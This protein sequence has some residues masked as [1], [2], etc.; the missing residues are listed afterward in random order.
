M[1]AASARPR[2]HF[3]ALAAV[4]TALGFSLPG[5]ALTI[6]YAVDIPS[7]TGQTASA[8]F[9][10]VDATTLQIV[11]T[12]TTLPGDS[13]ATAGS[14]ILAAIAFKLPGTAVI[15]GSGHTAVIA[16][17][18]E[19]VNFDPQGAPPPI[20]LV[21]GD[22]VSGEWGATNGG[23][24]DFDGSTSL[25]GN[26][27]F[28]FV[29]TIG[30]SGVIQ[31]AG[32]NRDSTSGLDGPQGGLLDESAV[33]GG[34]GVV[35]NAVVFTLILDADPGTVG[36]QGLSESQQSAF[37]A[38]LDPDSRVMYNSH[39]SFGKPIPEPETVALVALGLAGLVVTGRARR[40]N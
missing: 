40:P 27:L 1:A 25:L 20:E 6:N 26:E 37:L 5:E 30:S 4:A 8:D 11:L 13:T 31:F 35:D 9:T 29:S 21:G 34:A 12:E 18:S 10:F 3:Y 38:S 17:G 22:D 16:L 39:E 15:A 7:P 14:A 28:D 23:K 19:S 32:A 24:V 2:S 36:N 33:A